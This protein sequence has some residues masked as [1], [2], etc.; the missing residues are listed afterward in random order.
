M[1]I[2]RGS[3]GGL[4][5]LESRSWAGTLISIQAFAAL[6]LF[7]PPHGV[8]VG[9]APQAPAANTAE[10]LSVTGQVI[11]E[12]HLTLADWNALPRTKVTAKGKH[13]PQPRVYEG[14][15]LMDL[16]AKAGLPTGMEMHG[17]GMT[18]GVVANAADNYHVLFSLG[19][20]D[21]NFGAAVV[22][23]ADRADGQP[24][25]ANDGPLRIV[26]VGDKIGARWV[27]RLKSFT[28]VQVMPEK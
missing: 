11:Q 10:L 7:L 21:P 2:H 9:A 28:V 12:L 19:E 23:V 4:A 24:F 8:L 20:L 5:R 25:P 16:L 13:D 14:V 6:L 3:G 27:H 15:A 17:K 18:L 26:V 22:L 1:Q